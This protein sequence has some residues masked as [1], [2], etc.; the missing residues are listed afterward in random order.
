MHWKP[1]REKP[2]WP[3]LCKLLCRREYCTSKHFATSIFCRHIIHSV[4]ILR[5]HLHWQTS[6][7]NISLC[8]LLCS[9]WFRGA[10]CMGRD[11]T[12]SLL[13]LM[14]QPPSFGW[15]QWLHWQRFIDELSR[16]LAVSLLAVLCL[17]PSAGIW[18]TT[19]RTMVLE[20]VFS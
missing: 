4:L 12:D 20:A 10:Q 5:H 19:V 14:C 3:L 16:L 9:S 13:G 15:D 2:S 7:K 18:R 8:N 17:S 1:L 11:P 6:L